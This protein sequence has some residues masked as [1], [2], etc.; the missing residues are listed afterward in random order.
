[1]KHKRAVIGI[2]CLLM[3]VAIGITACSKSPVETGDREDQTTT[4][5]ITQTT[6]QT[7][8]DLSF[9]DWIGMLGTGTSPDEE[10]TKTENN[11]PPLNDGDVVEAVFTLGETVTAVEMEQTRKVIEKRMT[12]CGLEDIEVYTD[13][14][15]NEV[16]A[17]FSWD[18]DDQESVSVFVEQLGMGPTLEFRMGSEVVLQTDEYG[19]TVE[20]PTGEL[21]ISG[22]NVVSAEVQTDPTTKWSVVEVVMD[23]RGT[24]AFAAA[25]AE[26]A[27]KKGTISIWL[28]DEMIFNPQVHEAITDGK[29]LITGMDSTEEAELLADRLNAGTIPYRVQVVSWGWVD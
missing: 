3:A 10:T 4:Q 9:L 5:A 28:D 23:D 1:M 12:K 26:Q 8:D 21:V 13:L 18:K 24:A 16:I 17:R 27:A 2:V 29:V 25:T 11:L 20:V 15:H 6:T 22:K 19:N 7:G 14:V